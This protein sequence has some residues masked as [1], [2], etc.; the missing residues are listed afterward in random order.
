MS[1]K[2]ILTKKLIDSL[3]IAYFKKNIKKSVHIS[4]EAVSILFDFDVLVSSAYPRLVYKLS[5][6]TIE[7]MEQL[8]TEYPLCKRI[9]EEDVVVKI[10]E[11]ESFMVNYG[12]E[13][14]PS[15]ITNVSDL[16]NGTTKVLEKEFPNIKDYQGRRG[17]NFFKDYKLQKRNNKMLDKN[18]KTFSNGDYF[19]VMNDTHD[20]TDTCD[21]FI[22]GVFRF[23]ELVMP[24]YHPNCVCYIKEISKEEY[25]EKK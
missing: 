5:K 16:L 8:Y 6:G 25:N 19:E 23:D 20:D 17:K 21:S 10:D 1:N 11:F 9:L 13:Y 14:L 3:T 18:I 12:N 2:V 15:K 22:G 24:P 7:S 4:E